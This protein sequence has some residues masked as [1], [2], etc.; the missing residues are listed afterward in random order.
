MPSADSARTLFTHRPFL[1][2]FVG[3]GFSEF[4]YQIAA[5]ALGW[6]LYA[7]TN[8]AFDLGL[9]GLTQ[10]LP[11]ALLTLLAGHVADRYDRRRV[12]QFC[13]IV[14]ALTAAFL[15]W[16]SFAGWL[17]APEIFAAAAIF[18]AAIA[19]EK[20]CGCG[21]SAERYARRNAAE[22]HGAFHRSP[23]GRGHQRAGARRSDLCVGTRRAICSDRDVLAHGGFG[24]WRHCARSAREGGGGAVNGGPIRGHRVRA[25][26]SGDIGN[27]FARSLRRALGWGDGFAPDLRARHPPR[28]AM[29]LG[30]VARSA[31]RGR[32]HHDGCA[33]PLRDQ[34]SSRA[35]DVPGGG[36]LRL[37]DAHLCGLAFDLALASRARG[38][39]GG[40]YGQ[41]G[42]Q[43]SPRPTGDARCDAG[44]GQRGE[45]P[46]RQR[47]LPARRIRERRN[48][49]PIRRNPR[50]GAGRDRHNFR[51]ASMDEIVSDV[52]RRRA[53]GVADRFAGILPGAL[54]LVR[55]W[56]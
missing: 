19:F 43:D 27:N 56:R 55:T 8:S 31:G 15:A 32:S 12:V 10:F 46:I 34:T 37:G 41:H 18:G 35:Q 6:Q 49:G 48:R 2:Y 30:L 9:V 45:F 3:H 7:L 23:A 38:H 1:L 36:R 21:A 52:A 50:G 51:R 16:G 25:S 11:T 17:S 24:L 4:S 26:Q 5:V 20:S 14:E 42:D 44:P 53:I 33:R 47:F 39:G 54:K 13:Q 40:G 22:R 29:G 28:R